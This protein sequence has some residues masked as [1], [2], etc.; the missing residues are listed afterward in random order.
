MTPA[1]ATLA[2]VRREMAAMDLVESVCGH[3]I[4]S[5]SPR[6]A[7]LRAISQAAAEQS[8]RDSAEAKAV[9]D[10]MEARYAP[11]AVR[12][13]PYLELMG[14]ETLAEANRLASFRTGLAEEKQIKAHI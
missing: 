3:S 6:R 7:Q 13:S 2:M 11:K 1:E 10:R 12:A 8:M 14:D 9:L 5:Q 4:P